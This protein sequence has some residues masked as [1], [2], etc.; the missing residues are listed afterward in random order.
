MELVS[1]FSRKVI[2][3]DSLEGEYPFLW[4][5][6]SAAAFLASANPKEALLLW[7]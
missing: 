2:L 7:P 6:T 1:E 5:W 4:A 3:D